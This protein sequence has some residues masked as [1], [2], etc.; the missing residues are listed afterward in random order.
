MHYYLLVSL[1]PACNCSGIVIHQGTKSIMNGLYHFLQGPKQSGS[2]VDLTPTPPSTSPVYFLYSSHTC[3]AVAPSPQHSS[4]S[5]SLYCLDSYYQRS[6]IAHSFSSLRFLP[7]CPLNWEAFI[8][9]PYIMSKSPIPTFL[10]LLGVLHLSSTYYHPTD[11]LY[12]LLYLT[13]TYSPSQPSLN[14]KHHESKDCAF[15][16]SL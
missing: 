12:I 10:S 6:Y 14:Y 4:I 15:D 13:N 7:K 8:P 5:E 16:S 3:L 9:T 2:T 1:H 11:F